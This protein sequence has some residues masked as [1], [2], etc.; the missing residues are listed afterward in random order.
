MQEVLTIRHPFQSVEEFQRRAGTKLGRLVHRLASKYPQLQKSCGLKPM[1]VTLSVAW[2]LSGLAKAGNFAAFEHIDEA[3]S[4]PLSAWGCAMTPPWGCI[5]VEGQPFFI[6][7]SEQGMLQFLWDDFAIF[8]DYEGP[9]VV[10]Q[11]F[12]DFADNRQ[13]LAYK[14]MR[15]E[16]ATKEE[17]TEVAAI[18]EEVITEE[19]ITEEAITEEMET[20]EPNESTLPETTLRDTTL[21]ESTEKTKESATKTTH[22]S[23]AKLVKGV[24]TYGNEQEVKDLLHIFAYIDHP[25]KQTEHQRGILLNHLR[26]LA[27]RIPCAAENH[28]YFENN[29]GQVITKGNGYIKESKQQEN[30]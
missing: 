12:F 20:D 18:T 19:A 24:M 11:P 10:S 13:T 16:E 29:V 6:A 8:I 7:E 25:D 28:Y 4:P 21:R 22:D 15:E 17:T 14:A 3:L 23:L 5:T 9:E 2:G 27:C 26:D 1:L 30:D